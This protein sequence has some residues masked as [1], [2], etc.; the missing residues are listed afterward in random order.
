MT[1][2]DLELQKSQILLEFRDISRVSDAITAKR[3][4]IDPYRQ[5]RN[6]SP[7]TFQQCIDCVDRARRSSARGR[8]MSK[9]SLHTH[10][11]VARLP[12]VS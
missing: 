8:Q 4:K 11:A 10:T 5:R 1:L 9:R 3:M 12:G 6:C 7:C 2:D